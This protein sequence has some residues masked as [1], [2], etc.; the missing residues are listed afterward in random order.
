MK[1][2][3]DITTCLIRSD[4]VPVPLRIVQ[5]SDLHDHLYGAGQSDLISA[6]D[7][8]HPDLIVCTGDLFDRR[9]PMR[10]DNAFC[11]VEKLVSDYRV[12]ITEGNHE[13][14]LGETGNAYLEALSS[15]GATI[16]R[17]ASVLYYGINVIGLKQRPAREELLNLILPERFNLVLSH[18]PELFQLYASCGADLVLC[19][20]AHGGQIRFGNTALIA[21][22]QGLFPKYTSGLYHEGSTSM[23][24]S[25]GLGDTVWIPRI[26]NPHELNLICLETI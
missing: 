8:L 17:S 20:H 5:I 6:V 25:K 16:L 19:G 10:K 9:R 2:S 3:F 12:L 13:A 24:V 11:L 14:C 18:R 7:S 1:N 21:P 4:R 15:A 26:N 22:Q 23:F